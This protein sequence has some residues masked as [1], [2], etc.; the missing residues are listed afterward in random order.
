MGLKICISIICI[1]ILIILVITRK[2]ILNAIKYMKSN[3]LINGILKLLKKFGYKIIEVFW[4]LILGIII[5]IPLFTY[6]IM[7]YFYSISYEQYKELLDIILNSNY[8]VVIGVIII[9]YLFRNQLKN[10]IGQIKEVNTNGVVFG[11]Q[12]EKNLEKNNSEEENCDII[13]EENED[14]Y[15]EIKDKIS[16]NKSI[17]EDTKTNQNIIYELEE[18]L[19]EKDKV[20]KKN[21]FVNIKEH[22]AKTTNI[23]LVYM[24]GKYKT[25]NLFKQEELEQILIDTF[26]KENAKINFDI[27]TKAIIQFLA[28]NKIIDTE[29]DKNYCITEYG[30]EFLS[31][32]FE[33]RC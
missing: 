5:L 9:V 19:K 24:Y 4:I 6:Y 27:E 32:L 12:L 10:K 14:V 25:L 29:D 8:V 17:P 7:R 21:Q 16:D 1:L 22:I 20:I 26:Q 23:I 30:V 11:T 15:E 2:N 31:F 3:K 13:S 18:Q 28:T 33:G